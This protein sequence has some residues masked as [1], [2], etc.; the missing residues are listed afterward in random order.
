[1][2]IRKPLL[3]ALL[4]GWGSTQA[5]AAPQWNYSYN[6]LGLVSQVDGPR[7]DVTDITQFEYNTKG[8]LTQ[9]TNALGHTTELQDYDVYGNPGTLIDA[10]GVQTTFTYDAR[11]R[12]ISRTLHSVE[13][14]S[15]QHYAYSPAGDLTRITYP[16]D[17]WIAFEY[18]A[19]RRLVAIANQSSERIEYTL[20][21]MG[22]R[23]AEQITSGSG[24]L[25]HSVTYVYDELGRMLNDVGAS[26]QTQ[27]YGYDANGNVLQVTDPNQ[28]TSHRAYDALQRLVSEVDPYQQSTQYSY[29]PADNLTQVTDPRGVTTTYQYDYL[30]RLIER[31]SPSTGITTYTYDDADNILTQTDAKG[32]ITRYQYDALNRLTQ[33]SI[34]GHPEQTITYEYDAYSTG[35]H[36]N[37]GTGRLT[38][39]TDSQGYVQY[40]Y[41]ERG[42]IIEKLR[43]LNTTG[44]NQQLITHYEWNSANQLTAITY[45]SGMAIHYQWTQ[46]KVSGIELNT[47]THPNTPLASHITYQPYGGIETLTWGNGLTL[48]RQYDL[49]GRLST[50]RISSLEDLTYYYDPASNITQIAPYSGF[51]KDYHYDA[52]NRLTEEVIPEATKQYTYDEVGNRTER[53]VTTQTADGSL[54]TSRV[55][56]RYATD[57]NRL[58]HIWSRPITADENG[59]LLNLKWDR[60]YQY[61]VTNRLSSVLK[62]GSPLANFYYNA[63]GERLRKETP[64]Y[65]G[66]RLYQYG[67]NGQL[68]SEHF[69]NGQGRHYKT[70]NYIWLGSQPIAMVEQLVNTSHAVYAEAIYYL[71]TDHLNTPQRITNAQQQVIWQWQ[72]DAFGDGKEIADPDGDGKKFWFPLRFPGQYYD[73]ETGLNYNYY[74]DYDRQLGRYVQSDPIGLEGGLNTY[75]YVNS[76]PLKFIDPTGESPLTGSGLPC[77][78][79]GCLPIEWPESVKEQKCFVCDAKVASCISPSAADASLSCRKCALTKGGDKLACTSCANSVIGAGACFTEHCSWRKCKIKDC[80]VK[81]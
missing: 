6:A 50:Q 78:G 64:A 25:T 2:N 38:G 13:G 79:L 23:T 74:R 18:D 60:H 12:M 26:A 48:D 15:T 35:S 45:P 43:A 39:F 7:R 20:D 34:D 36:Y 41:D 30:G 68:L 57:S 27:T 29:D 42:N 10:N 65:G 75:A 22:N 16:D 70:R 81:E 53:T 46:G 44:L 14:P 58:S 54:K 8:Q 32:V 62:N 40:R 28:H 21:A 66:N 5:L 71:H 59:N 52:L 51:A 61:D 69:I 63:L 80:P 73:G 11:G 19:A 72:G 49:D 31:N 77:F 1:M 55:P 67:D 76:N 24:A 56:Y 37:M 4:A 9:I 3:I 17:R 33:S 47:T